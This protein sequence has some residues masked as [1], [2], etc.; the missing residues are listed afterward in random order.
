MDAFS[1]GQ[2]SSVERSL[3]VHQSDAGTLR[4]VIRNSIL[5]VYRKELRVEKTK[6]PPPR[7]CNLF[8][9]LVHKW[10]ISGAGYQPKYLRQGFK[11]RG[12]RQPSSSAGFEHQWTGLPD[13]SLEMTTP[14]TNVPAQEEDHF[15]P[16][17]HGDPS[18]LRS[19][20]TE[21]HEKVFT[22]LE[23]EAPTETLKN[24]QAQCLRSI[25]I[26]SDALTNYPYVFNPSAASY[27]QLKYT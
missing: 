10:S 22:F 25:T 18:R 3:H 12:N 11:G 14:G 16:T 19:L 1:F 27:A 26:I 23:K 15:Q 6:V 5:Q 2:G 24:V 21:L 7:P 8:H 9:T 4:I 20:C 13:L 17:D